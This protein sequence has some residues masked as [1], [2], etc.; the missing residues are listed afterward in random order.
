[1]YC[2]AFQK[3]VPF[4]PTH[5]LI[6]D[7]LAV[8]FKIPSHPVYQKT[9]IFIE[10]FINVGSGGRDF[11]ARGEKLGLFLVVVFAYQFIAPARSKLK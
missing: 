10:H 9:D 1:M 6:A 8:A 4:I 5:D 3:F 2:Q 11:L 7:V